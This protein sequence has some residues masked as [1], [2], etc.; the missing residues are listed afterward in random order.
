MQKKSNPSPELNLSQEPRFLS[1]RQVASQLAVNERTVWRL[2]TQGKLT[3]KK[4]GV[5]T[6]VSVAELTRYIASLP[7]WRSES[8]Q[9]TTTSYSSECG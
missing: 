5:R 9:R 6:L 8:R 1:I 4:L 3:A 7:D 2:L